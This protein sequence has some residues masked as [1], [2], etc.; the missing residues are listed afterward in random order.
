MGICD[1]LN[2]PSKK[3]AIASE[4]IKLIDELVAAKKGLS[5]FGLK[6]SY[7]AVKGVAPGY[8][9]GAIE[10]LIP[11]AFTAL[12]PMWGEGIKTGSPVEY[13]AQNSSRAAD[14]LLGV[15]DAKIK[16]ASN[17]IVQGAYKNL[18]NS[19]KGDVEEAIPGLAKIID[20]H[21]K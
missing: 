2:D 7:S 13:L 16:R 20:N 6:A 18:R 15:T 14:A 10:R 1:G 8:Y 19:V 3:E 5:G 9:A 11:E 21:T 12:D 4:C 17:R